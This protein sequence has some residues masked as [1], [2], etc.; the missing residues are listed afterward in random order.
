M[1][2]HYSGA[3]APQTSSMAIVSLVAGI[4]GFTLIPVLGSI[5]AVITGPMAK[6]E[7]LGSA[8]RLGGEGLAQ[9]GIILGW[10]GIALSVLGICITGVVI[11][12][13]LCLGLFG[14]ASGEWSTI[15]PSIFFAF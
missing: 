14:V 12:L 2:D 3:P 4:L 13:P 9:A 1:S 11:A 15:L 10:A 6:K 7:I 8:G 5:V